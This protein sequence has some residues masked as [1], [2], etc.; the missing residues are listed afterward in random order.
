MAAMKFGLDKRTTLIIT[1]CKFTQAK[2]IN[3]PKNNKGLNIDE[4]N[5]YCGNLEADD[6]K[7]KQAKQKT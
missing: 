7:H 6:I 2:G 3:L 5:K 4:R 1:K